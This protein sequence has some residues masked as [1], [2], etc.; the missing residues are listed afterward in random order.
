MRIQ[1]AEKIKIGDMIVVK[2]KNQYSVAYKS[3]VTDIE[4]IELKGQKF[5]DFKLANGIWYGYKQCS[6]PRYLK[7]NS[8]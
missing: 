1:D 5:I 6:L 8:I 7:N 3:T 2:A 4:V